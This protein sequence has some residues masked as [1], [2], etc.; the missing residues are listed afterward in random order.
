[1]RDTLKFVASL[2]RGTEIVF[3]YAI[4]PA[5][6]GERDRARHDEAARLVATRGEP[7]RT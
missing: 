3:D 7:W 6:L 4:P 5:A 2:P 1:V